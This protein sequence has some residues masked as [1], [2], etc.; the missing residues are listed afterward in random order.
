[1]CVG[2]EVRVEASPE[3]CTSELSDVCAATHGGT[4]GVLMYK[5]SGAA[6]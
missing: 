4:T 1:M 5:L 6:T 3:G 2:G